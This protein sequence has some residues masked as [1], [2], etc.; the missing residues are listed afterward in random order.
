MRPAEEF[1]KM[2]D[3]A[4]MVAAGTRPL[5]DIRGIAFDLAPHA[6]EAWLRDNMIAIQ[7]AARSLRIQRRT[8]A[9]RFIR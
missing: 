3:L 5:A 2:R 1:Q 6:E 9:S 8:I 7:I 4:M